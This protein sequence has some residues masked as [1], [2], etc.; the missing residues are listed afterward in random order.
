[1]LLSCF[2][3]SYDGA[4][5]DIL[6]RRALLLYLAVLTVT[7]LV[8]AGTL[9]ERR[10]RD[11]S[12]VIE[13]GE[14][15]SPAAVQ[16][17]CLF[18]RADDADR[19]L[20]GMPAEDESLDGL[21]FPSP[22]DDTPR[23]FSARRLEGAPYL[24][25]AG[26]DLRQ[27][28]A[29][30]WQQLAMLAAG[31]LFVALV[32]FVALRRH[33]SLLTTKRR[34]REEACHRAAAQRRLEESTAEL[35]IAAMAFDTHLGMFITDA[36]GRVLRVNRTFSHITGFTAAEV[37][38]QNPRMWASGRHAA[39]FYREM[40]QT[41]A[42]EGSWQGEVWN[43]RKSGEVYP[44]WLTISAIHDDH[45]GV[46][47]YVATLTDLSATKAAESTIQRLAFYDPLTGLPN[48][49]L[50]IDRLGEVIKHTRRRDHY[51]ALLLVGL[52]NFKAYNS[53]LGHA[54]GDTLLRRLAEGLRGRL[55]ESDTLARWGG[56][57]FALLVQDLGDEPAHAARGAERLGDKLLHEVVRLAGVDDATLPLSASIG[58]ALFHDDELD[59]AEAIQQAELAMYEAKREGGA[60]LR[61]FDRAMQTQ[62]VER[63]HLEADLE[64]A[65]DADQLRLFYQPQ[66]DAAGVTV[67]LEA[68]LRWEHPGRG[69]VSPGVF[70]PLAEE[71]GRIVA[72]GGWVL[73]QACRRLA[74]WAGHP[75]Y[76]ALSIA[77][78]VS[79]VQFREAGFVDGV[80]E[81]LAVT[82]A[83]PRRLVLEVTES[84]FLQEPELARESMLALSAL[85]VRF[86]LDD[87]GTG[88]SSLGYLKRLPLDELK[89]DQS[90]VRDLLA[91]PA[92]AAIV[93]T[94]IALADKLSLSVI[95]EGVER[96]A[97]ANWLREHGCLR[98]QGYLYARPAPLEAGERFP[99]LSA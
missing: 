4:P 56:D 28:L 79:P 11:L 83:E 73:E 3:A 53:T 12:P 43:R 34:L 49:R 63:A 54:R 32:G 69:M 76:G 46:R 31:W 82:G 96:E 84:L 42:A 92:D 19:A 70:I 16:A 20:G 50:L 57:Q 75:A 38:G 59:A 23:L 68:L 97:Q 51:G 18:D 88:Y 29:P 35:K 37:V 91:S 48:R 25:V 45:G 71:S 65:L 2:L 17:M 39:A 80:R 60:A 1:M 9:A 85:G 52:D 94:I 90:F 55:R 24:V 93:E 87:F 98:F 8:M 78:N 7:A 74:E 22:L 40:W 81:T 86:A 14:E 61:F 64:R 95:A 67:G 6:R 15:R 58:I 89:I 13:L 72:I 66:V 10:L 77:V 99:G 36:Q 47:H 27:V 21:I 44:Q 5:Q 33:L 30:W 41:I 62:V 26:R